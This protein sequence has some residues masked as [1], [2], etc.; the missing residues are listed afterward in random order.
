MVDLERKTKAELIQ[1]LEDSEAKNQ[2]LEAKI[3]AN[4][5]QISED[6][7]FSRT[8]TE[9]EEHLKKQREKD[10]IKRMTHGRW[11]SQAKYQE[12]LEDQKRV[13]RQ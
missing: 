11:V 12:Y 2:E 7:A 8:P 6:M 10:Y 9:R 3:E 13:I 5:E 4:K 1:L